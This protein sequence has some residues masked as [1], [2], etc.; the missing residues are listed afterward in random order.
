MNK[1]IKGDSCLEYPDKA[2][3]LTALQSAVTVKLRS[4][5]LRYRAHCEQYCTEKQSASLLTSIF[6]PSTVMRVSPLATL[7][8]GETKTCEL[9]NKQQQG[10]VKQERHQHM[11]LLLLYSCLLFSPSSHLPRSCSSHLS[12]SPPS[13]TTPLPPALT[14]LTVLGYVGDLSPSELPCLLLS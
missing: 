14:L 8:P 2:T 9:C 3:M 11:T 4:T 12:S 6:M 7:S 13:L 1:T 5:H 10:G